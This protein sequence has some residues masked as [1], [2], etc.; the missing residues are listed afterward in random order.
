METDEGLYHASPQT[1]GRIA[2][3]SIDTKRA[4]TRSHDLQSLSISSEK[5][6]L[7]G[8]I[9]LYKADKH[10]LIERKYN[11][12]RIFQGQIYQLWAQYLCMCEMG[13]DVKS[14]AFYEISTNKMFPI[15]LPDEEQLNEF[16]HFLVQFRSFDPSSS[17]TINSDKCHHCIYSNLCDKTEDENVYQ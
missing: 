2:H 15:T 14:I 3:Q 4:S 7:I 9:D 6:R 5:Y 8:K 10:L 11:L 16:E 17:I 13:Y 1:Q 12:K